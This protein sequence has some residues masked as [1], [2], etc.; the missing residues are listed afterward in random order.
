MFVLREFRRILAGL[1]P[2]NLGFSGFGFFPANPF[3]TFYI[4]PEEISSDQIIDY[5]IKI[6]TNFRKSLRKKRLAD[7]N[8]CSKFKLSVA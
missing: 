1:K 5:C 8:S 7:W 6:N 4:K 3:G 2:F